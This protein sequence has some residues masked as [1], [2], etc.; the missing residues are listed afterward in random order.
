MRET[1]SSLNDVILN[2]KEFAKRPG[3]DGQKIPEK[4]LTRFEDIF[5]AVVGLSHC[6]SP[7][8]AYSIVH[9]YARTHYN[10]SYTYALNDLFTRLT[11]DGT[12]ST[13][14]YGRDLDDNWTGQAGEKVLKQ[15]DPS[16]RFH[17]A[18]SWKEARFCEMS[19]VIRHCINALVIMGL[20]PKQA[21]GVLASE[22][23]D[24]V[25][26]NAPGTG[27]GETLQLLDSVF[28]VVD[29]IGNRLIPSVETGD[30]SYLFGD[31]DV[32]ELNEEWIKAN[33]VVGMY[34]L[35]R[36]DLLRNKYDITTEHDI[37]FMLD[38]MIETYTAFKASC[39]QQIGLRTVVERIVKLNKMLTDVRIMFQDAPLRIQPFGVLIRGDTGVA[40]SRV[41][42]LTNSAVC[43]V[44]GFRCDENSTV[45]FNG[46]DKFQSE[47]RN[48]HVTA[49]FDDMCNTRADRTEGNPLMKI[50]QFLNNMHISALSPEADKKGKMQVNCKLAFVTT[51]TRDLNAAYY[52]VNPASVLRRFSKIVTVKLKPECL[53][54][55]TGLPHKKYVGHPIPDIWLFDVSHIKVT[56]TKG[57]AKDEYGEVWDLLDADI[58]Q[59]LEFMKS[60][61]KDHFVQQEK[62]VASATEYAK[63]VKCP[64]HGY[65]LDECFMCKGDFVPYNYRRLTNPDAKDTDENALHE[66]PRLQ[67][68]SGEESKKVSLLQKMISAYNCRMDRLREDERRE[69]EE[70]NL[71]NDF[72]ALQVPS[73]LRDDSEDKWED[74]I[75]PSPMD[76]LCELT[77]NVGEMLK[78]SVPTGK[79]AGACAIIAGIAVAYFQFR[80]LQKTF[81]PQGAIHSNISE[82]DNVAFYSHPEQKD[83]WRRPDTTCVKLSEPSSTTPYARMVA[84]V[85]K[86]IVKMRFYVDPNVVRFC[87]AVPLGSSDWLVPLHTMRKFEG[88]SFYVEADFRSSGTNFG[89][90]FKQLVDSSCWAPVPGRDLAVLRV[91]RSGSTYDTT[92]F[93][94]PTDGELPMSTCTILRR[95][96]DSGTVVS[97]TSKLSSKHQIAPVDIEPYDACGYQTDIP[98]HSGMC[99]AMAITLCNTPTFVGVHTAGMTGTRNGKICPV[100]KDV[101]EIAR[102]RIAVYGPINEGALEREIYG[103]DAGYSDKIHPKNPVNFI[104]EN[105]FDYN[106]EIMGQNELPQNRFSSV[107]TESPLSSDVQ[108][109]M[110]IPRN[111]FRPPVTKDY[112][113]LQ[114]DLEIMSRER[115]SIPPDLVRKAL[116]DMKFEFDLFLSDHPD[117]KDKV[118]KLSWKHSLNGIPGAVGIDAMNWN[119][120]MM[121]NL[122]KSKKLF[123][124]QIAEDDEV[125]WDLMTGPE[126]EAA[127]SA[128]ARSYGPGFCE[129]FDVKARVNDI[130]EKLKSGERLYVIFKNLLKDEAISEKKVREHKVRVMSGTEVAFLIVVRMYFLT[131]SAARRSYPFRFESAVG[132][133]AHGQ[134]WHNYFQGF[135]DHDRMVNGD[136]KGFDKRLPVEITMAVFEYYDHIFRRCGM[137]NDF[138]KVVRGIATEICYPV[139][140]I[141]G[142]ILL[143]TGS[144]PSGQGLTVEV[145]NDGNR[146]L[147]RCAYYS[148][149]K[150]KIPPPLFARQIDLLCYGDDNIM[151]VDP[152]EP[153]FNHTSV[154]NFLMKYGIE[155]TMA[156]KESESRPFI[157]IEECDLLK[158]KFRFHELLGAVAGPIEVASIAKSLHNWRTDAK[159]AE[160]EYLAGVLENA[161]TEFFY[162]GEEVFDK[163]LEQLKMVAELHDAKIDPLDAPRRIEHYVRWPS[164]EMLI[165]RYH[166]T[167]SVL[168]LYPQNGIFLQKSYIMIVKPYIKF[169]LIGEVSA[170]ESRIAHKR[171]HRIALAEEILVLAHR[172]GGTIYVPDRLSTTVIGMEYYAGVFHRVS[173]MEC[174]WHILHFYKWNSFVTGLACP[175]ILDM[176]ELLF[177]TK[178]EFQVVNDEEFRMMGGYL[179]QALLSKSESPY[180]FYE[181]PVRLPSK[182]SSCN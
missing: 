182:R 130:I 109:V 28:H 29:W 59:Y 77:S 79:I 74:I 170:R 163:R 136:Y 114:R 152:S 104:P 180:D 131:M 65:P 117:F 83:H 158:R 16:Q 92:K 72:D 169:D 147:M 155:Y 84:K 62:I 93:M 82:E 42:D 178:P 18:D 118:G 165:E 6:K 125:Y 52:S 75:P 63:C 133:N 22:L 148:F 151:S 164:K 171:N 157:S 64:E 115:E 126:M 80:K 98:T 111:Y 167:S 160:G 44:N 175:V 143:L 91:L 107:F 86:N 13:Y 33:D 45:R 96:A 123:R 1:V 67:G 156:D 32:K 144:N 103:I 102:S 161:A 87:D 120:S 7:L 48:H 54:K 99:G 90:R 9:L 141:K 81:E 24:F 110:D 145:N 166:D 149:H 41:T 10:K 70:K 162:H 179:A 172:V 69:I 173:S 112:L 8:Q 49:V 26:F 58:K 53:D 2:V 88:K 30:M 71:L 119:S 3:N 21:K 128:L 15:I 132:C 43:A 177:A 113:H 27:K 46:D 124:K 95:D 50:I 108:K 17:F 47:Y 19:N 56:R 153:F 66:D 121:G 35:G 78:V 73:H 127:F 174:A 122:N 116:E 31:D 168:K 25:N 101:I 36:M 68:Q 39:P 97:Y 37:L 60:V 51:N 4:I 137:D 94:L 138:L 139:Y 140:E 176:S 146:M 129:K 23:Y 38:K 159:Q 40:K 181:A 55:E 154:S 135:R 105:E 150:D 11:R 34:A 85:S 61:S 134:D 142:L 89:K 20:A 76:R 12:L 14:V 100:A 57:H 106:C 5:A